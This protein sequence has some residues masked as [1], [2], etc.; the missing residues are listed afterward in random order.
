M[1]RPLWL[2]GMM[3]SGKSTIGRIA[4]DRLG[5]PFLDTDETVVARLGSSIPAVW[6]E[7]GE[8]GFRR[9]ESEEL[10]KAAMSGPCVVATGGGAVIEPD[11]VTLMRRTGTVVWLAARPEVLAERLQDGTGRPLL[12][13]NPLDE[14]RR[15]LSE[16]E[17]LYRSAAHH[18]LEED[19]L[20]QLVR[21]VIAI[22]EGRL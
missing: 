3:G 21:G 13:S 10:T 5:V 4:A 6:A 15:I 22:A 17:P 1:D 18:I 8:E 11:N 9:F 7:W 20:D 16:R 2:V 12:A 14:L 19:L